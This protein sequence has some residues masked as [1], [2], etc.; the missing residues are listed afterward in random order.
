MLKYKFVAFYY[1]FMYQSAWHVAEI[2]GI[3]AIFL[4]TEMKFGH[5]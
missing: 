2:L 1:D 3:K 4:S 5:H